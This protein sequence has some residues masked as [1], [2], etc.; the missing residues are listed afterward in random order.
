M[1]RKDLEMVTKPDS[2]PPA[3]KP[4]PS[5]PS[6]WPFLPRSVLSL[7]PPLFLSISLLSLSLYFYQIIVFHL[8][9]FFV[10]P[11][12][13]Y[14]RHQ[15]PTRPDP[16]K[17][18]PFPHTSSRSPVSPILS[19]PYHKPRASPTYPCIPPQCPG[20]TLRKVKQR[21]VM[22]QSYE[23]PCSNRRRSSLKRHCRRTMLGPPNPSR[24]R[25][26]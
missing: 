22:A 2:T 20:N 15:C 21:C 25:P 11:N 1:T 6:L 9:L 13:T 3:I 26:P 23:R 17:K 16:S 18:A 19:P 12:H 7:T 8:H 5:H 24:M 14:R 10:L 4:I